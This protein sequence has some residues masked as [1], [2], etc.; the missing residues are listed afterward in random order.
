MLEVVAKIQHE[1]PY[2]FDFRTGLQKDRKLSIQR[3]M[4]EKLLGAVRVGP[5]PKSVCT[6]QR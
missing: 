6:L 5:A 1:R 2:N 3:G 4:G